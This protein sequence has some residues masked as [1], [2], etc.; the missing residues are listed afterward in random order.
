VPIGQVF[1]VP[2]EQITMRPCTSE[3]LKAFE[4]S[5]QEFNRHKAAVVQTTSS[6]L[7]YSPHY[8]R[9][10]RAQKSQGD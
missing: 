10:S 8:L 6:G 2:P 3:E 1:F 7:A 5:W 9:Q 4:E